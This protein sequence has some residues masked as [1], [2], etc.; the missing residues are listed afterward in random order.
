MLAGLLPVPGGVGVVEGGLIYGLVRAGVPEEVAFAAVVLYRIASF[1]LPPVW[2]Y[3]AMRWLETQRASVIAVA[4]SASRAGGPDCEERDTWFLDQDVNAWTSLAYVV[5]GG[6][7]IALAIR[8]RLRPVF[9]VL[10]LLA[11]AEGVGS[12]MYHGGSGDPAV[13]ARRR[14]R[15]CDRLRRRLARRSACRPGRPRRAGGTVVAIVAGSVVWAAA[16]RRRT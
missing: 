1:Y 11:I 3:F 10:G 9:V 12:M 6:L 4:E 5:V 7:V 8:R 16:P 13:P 15:R 14:A 2:G